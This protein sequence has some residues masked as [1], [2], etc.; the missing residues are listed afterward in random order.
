MENNN[1]WTNRTNGR[2]PESVFNAQFIGKNCS[3]DQC[4]AIFVGLKEMF[5]C[6]AVTLPVGINKA[7]VRCIMIEF[8][9]K[10]L[11]M[12]FECDN[13]QKYNYI[14][15]FITFIILLIYNNLKLQMLLY[16]FQRR[17]SLLN[18]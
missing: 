8:Q 6:K 13:K 7:T 1:K 15:L 12:T 16:L 10:G 3:G 2:V 14:L 5:N 4:G 11:E 9:K 17:W 18:L